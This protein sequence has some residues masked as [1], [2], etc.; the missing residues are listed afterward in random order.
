MLNDSIKSYLEMPACSILS[1]T[2]DSKNSFKFTLMGLS[3]YFQYRFFSSK[4]IRDE[5][6]EP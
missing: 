5:E 3:S 6:F 4:N 2:W 1:Y